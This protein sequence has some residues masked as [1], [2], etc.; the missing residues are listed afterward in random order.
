MYQNITIFLDYEECP[1]GC[2]KEYVP[3]C[4][5]DGVTYSNEC[6]FKTVQCYE[7]PT[8]YVEYIG[9][10]SKGKYITNI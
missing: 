8:L 4:G 10:C 3:V 7:K 1:E 6:T 5:N 2:T 9:E